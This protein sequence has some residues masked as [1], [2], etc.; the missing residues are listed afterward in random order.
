MNFK[1]RDPQGRVRRPVRHR[2]YRDKGTLRPPHQSVV[3]PPEKEEK[4][5]RRQNV[6]HPL[7]QNSS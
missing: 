7:L 4:T 3:D 2:G 6:G 1:S 5:D